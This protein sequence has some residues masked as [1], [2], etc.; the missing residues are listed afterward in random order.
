MGQV[1]SEDKENDNDRSLIDT[2]DEIFNAIVER[3]IYKQNLVR[4]S[5]GE[6]IDLQYKNTNKETNA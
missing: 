5:N 6:L 1:C 4:T 2:N 3:Q